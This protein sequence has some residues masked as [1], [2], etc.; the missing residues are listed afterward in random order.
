MRQPVFVALLTI[1]YIAVL[2]LDRKNIKKYLF[3]GI[4]ALLLDIL[5]EAPYALLLGFWTYHGEPQLLGISVWTLI[6]YIHYLGFCYFMGNKTVEKVSK[7]MQR[8]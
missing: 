3:L 1:P 5:F 2:W 7:W 4:F 6:L 8:T